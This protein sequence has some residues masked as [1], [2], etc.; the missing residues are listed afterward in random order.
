MVLIILQDEI[1]AADA[2]A[3]L[4]KSRLA[5]LAYTSKPGSP[6]P[7]LRQMIQTR[8]NVLI[9][10]EHGGGA[11]DGTRGLRCRRPVAGDEV[12]VRLDR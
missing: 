8:K 6:F 11:E 3:V 9:M 12:R 5:D 1:K 4:K 7:T 10:A 2:V